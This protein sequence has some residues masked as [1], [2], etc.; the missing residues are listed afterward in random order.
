MTNLLD[1]PCDKKKLITCLLDGQAGQCGFVEITFIKDY[2]V[3]FL[4]HLA[5]LGYIMCH[6]VGFRIG[7]RKIETQF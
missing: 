2:S 5:I 3:P 7:V 4:A 1:F 6:S